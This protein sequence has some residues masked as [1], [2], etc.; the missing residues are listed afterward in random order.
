MHGLIEPELFY[1]PLKDEINCHIY[2]V[3]SQSYD[4]IKKEWLPLSSDKWI[5]DISQIN[6]R[7][8]S[9]S[10]EYVI[11]D[12]FG[13][14]VQLNKAMTSYCNLYNIKSGKYY[15]KILKSKY[16]DVNNEWIEFT[17][18]EDDNNKVRYIELTPQN[19]FYKTKISLL[20]DKENMSFTDNIY[21]DS[22]YQGT[23]STIDSHAYGVK[24]I[25]YFDKNNQLIYSTNTQN[26]GFHNPISII[27]ILWGTSG[28]SF[29]GYVLQNS[30]RA[31]TSSKFGLPQ[32]ND[33]GD[34]SD[35]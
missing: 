32:D 26:S 28:I 11:K 7:Y 27:E 15:L 1:M 9:T 8:K 21:S 22:V 20:Q 10:C 24:K 12:S 14:I 4:L 29:V 5:K 2:F 19:L 34:N 35:K 30:V 25:E 16:A 33:G 31:Y 13:N 6:L 17:L 18:D 3:I 23:E